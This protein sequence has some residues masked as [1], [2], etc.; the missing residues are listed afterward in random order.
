MKKPG[1]DKKKCINSYEE[2]RNAFFP[3][4]STREGLKN[5]PFDSAVDHA[6]SSIKTHA[7]LL[8]K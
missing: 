3:E 7:L 1:P 5:D 8:K 2:Y 6:K 4:L